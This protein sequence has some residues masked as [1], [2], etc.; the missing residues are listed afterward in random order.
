MSRYTPE[1][2]AILGRYLSN[3]DRNVYCIF[4]LPEEVIAV[5]FARVSRSPHS[6]R[7]NLLSLIKDR[8]LALVDAMETGA[9]AQGK[10]FDIE[11]ARKFHE[12]VVIGYGHSSVAEL[13]VAHVGVEDISRLASARLELSN[14][15]LSFIEYS[16]RYQRTERGDFYTPAELVDHPELLEA[17]LHLQDQ[18]YDVFE[19][20]IHGLVAHLRHAVPRREDE[21]EKAWAL[22]VDKIAFEDARYAL[23]LA[24]H[25]NLGI[26]GNG[27]ALRDSIVRLMSDP[28]SECRALAGALKDE[29]GAVLPVL[30]KYA[31]P[32]A[33]MVESRSA[34][35]ELAVRFGTG[36]GGGAAAGAGAGVAPAVVALADWTG[37]GA[38]GGDEL[39]ALQAIAAGLLAA[40]GSVPPGQLAAA[41]DGLSQAQLLELF[42][43]AVSG[44]GPH[45]NPADAT[46]RVTYDVAFHVSEACWH[47]LL[48]HCRR[49]EF[50]PG[51]PTVTGGWVVPPNVAAAGL[52]DLLGRAVRA[53]ASLFTRLAESLPDVA[54]YAVT[55]AH[56]RHTLARFDLWELFH[57]VN[58]RGSPDAQWEIRQATLALNDQVRRV[59]PNL[60][61]GPRRSRA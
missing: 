7:D 58:L 4:D 60:A 36:S 20:L 14:P 44:L 39:P 31:N 54:P 51:E 15:F 13:A 18:T 10:Q 30:L 12:R 17:Y 27:R 22:R 16:Q 29:V 34:V 50:A 43:A 26:T 8:E 33:Y 3:L 48:R 24:V 1:E 55:N 21:S 45:D 41:V 49:I 19:Q 28:Y 11:K 40:H 53:S 35:A 25:T 59:H 56:R 5:V 37:R 42:T 6:F 46:H 61:P 52:T 23:T 38:A 47:Q 57:L 32:S 9:G 2:Q